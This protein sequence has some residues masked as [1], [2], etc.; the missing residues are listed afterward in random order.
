MAGLFDLGAAFGDAI[1]GQGDLRPADMN[2]GTRGRPAIKP[3]RLTDY[4]HH[5]QR[6]MAD[7]ARRRKEN[8]AIIKAL[9]KDQ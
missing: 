7:F 9:Q 8:Q 3:G 5:Y 4:G 2:V 6:A 1:V